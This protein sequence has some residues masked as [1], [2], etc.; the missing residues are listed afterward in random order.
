MSLTLGGGPL[1]GRPRSDANYTFE[2]PAHRLLFEP[3]GRRLRA[4]VGTQTVLDSARVHLLHETGILPVAYVP[5]EDLDAGCLERT[6]TSTHC[7]FKGDAS[8]WSLRV[9]GRTLDDA[10]W[11]YERPQEGAAWLAGFAALAWDRPDGWLV[12]DEP[13]TGHLRDPYHRV[14]VHESAR[15][16]TVTVHGTVVATSTRP[17]LLFETSLPAR[18]YLPRADVAPGVLIPSDT[19]TTCP[20]K[21][22]AQHWH[23]HAADG[24]RVP[25]GAW[26]YESPLPEALKVAGHVCFLA[27]GIE[28]EVGDPV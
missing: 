17:K 15:P 22:E 6:D 20:Y 10:V 13:V 23:V 21:G 19:R 11:G 12:E 4:R 7:P 3:F 2:A 28:V 14:D 9:D 27:D 26:S 16:V 5:L 18:A 8:Y 24:T 1:A 25:D